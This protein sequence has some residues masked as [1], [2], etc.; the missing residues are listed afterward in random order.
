M[1]T[2]MLNLPHTDSASATAAPRLVRPMLT[3]DQRG[4][5]LTFVP[6]AAKP[7]TYHHLRAALQA[8]ALRSG[9][10]IDTCYTAPTAHVTIA[11]FV[12]TGAFFERDGSGGDA[13]AAAARHFVEV[14]QQINEELR[15]GWET[16]E[17]GEE[18]RVGSWTVGGEKGLEYQLGYLKFGRGTEVAEL[19]GTP[20]R[21]QG[22]ERKIESGR[23]KGEGKNEPRLRERIQLEAR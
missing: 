20:A 7:Y 21:Q 5:A 8:H 12:G 13:V 1:I 14:V 2:S 23:G 9:L 22:G 17:G 15:A 6:A 10:A 19:V 18:E 4:I 11:R 16:E 3:F